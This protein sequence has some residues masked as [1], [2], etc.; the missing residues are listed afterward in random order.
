MGVLAG[1]VVLVLVVLGLSAAYSILKA[2]SELEAA[3]AEIDSV[4][5]NPHYL[6]SSAGRLHAARVIAQVQSNINAAHSTLS[7]SPGVTAMWALPY[8]H[9]QRQV[10]FNLLSDVG[11]TTAAGRSL[12]GAVNTLVSE[13][14]GTT[15]SMTALATLHNRIVTAYAKLAPLGHPAPGIFPLLPPLASAEAHV[16]ADLTRLTGLLADGRQLTAYAQI[17][18]GADGPR[19]YFLAAENN[20]EMRDQG[21]VLSYALINT[22][23][24]TFDTTADSSIGNLA[25]TTPAPVPMPPGTQQV[26]AGFNP[27]QV[28]QSTNAPASF[29]WTGQDIQA[30]YAQATGQHIDGVIALDVPGLASLLQL[31]GPVRVAGV[32]V[33]IT[34]GNLATITLHDL[35]EGVPATADQTARRDILST[36]ARAVVDKMK[37]EHIDMAAFADT[38]AKDAAGRHLLAWDSVP[39]YEA[40]I[41]RFGGSGAVDAY[42]PTRTF[43]LAVE[44]GGANKLDYYVNVKQS[45]NVVLTASGDAEVI[46]TVTADNTTPPNVPAG[47]QYG[48]DGVNTF[49]PGQYLGLAF[50]WGPRGSTQSGSVPESGLTVSDQQLNVLPHQSQSV[51]FQTVIH[52]AVQNGRL[53]LIFVP[54]PRLHPVELTIHMSSEAPWHLSGPSLVHVALS[55]SLTWTW[56]ASK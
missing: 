12:L 6:L 34:A 1:I 21:A 8:L 2:R 24:G 47:Y 52:H 18:L 50:L 16:D 26:F 40:T 53:Q 44:D 10:L 22:D 9:T 4:T 20:A 7:D 56:E 15:L 48:P 32:P 46:T 13:S 51:Q 14:H 19:T 43:H 17:F 5:H 54:Q 45:E 3:K 25:L 36:I 23:D 41:R 37:V 42:D 27:T 35:Y 31:T 39:S 28:W 29:P 49:V 30:M 33:P 55:K 38:L 11:V